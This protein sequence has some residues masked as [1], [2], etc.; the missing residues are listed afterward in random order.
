MR[1][2]LVNVLD[3]KVVASVRDMNAARLLQHI[4]R[5]TTYISAVKIDK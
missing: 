3:G 1:F 4:M 2:E 5:E